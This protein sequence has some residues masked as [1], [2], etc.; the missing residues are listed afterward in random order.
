MMDRIQKGR[1][2]SMGKGNVANNSRADKHLPA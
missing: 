2:S 1:K